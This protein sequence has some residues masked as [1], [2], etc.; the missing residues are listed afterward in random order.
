MALSTK[1][2]TGTLPG[3]LLVVLW[4][5]RGRLF[6][7][8]DVLPL[9]PL[10][11]VGAA[12]GLLT[13][14]W[15]LAFN[16]SLGPEFDFTFVERILIAGRSVWFH[17]GKL[18]WPADLAFIYPRWQIDTAAWWSFAF[19]VGVAL[20]AALAWSVRQRSRGPLAAWLFFGGTLFPVL[21]FFNLYTYRYSLVANHY[22][23]LA[24][25]GIITLVAAV[26]TLGLTRRGPWR[27]PLGYAVCG[28]VLAALAATTWAESHQF[29][30]AETL[31]RTTIR[32]NPAC[33]LAYNNLGNILVSR[34]RLTDAREVYEQA[35]RL[36]PDLA[37]SFNGLGMA[38]VGQGDLERG[39]ESYRRAVALDPAYGEAFNNL[40]VALGRARL[41]EEAIRN[42]RESIRID[43]GYATAHYN[44]ANALARLGRFEEAE[45]HYRAALRIAPEMAFAHYYLG[46]TLLSQGKGTE[47]AGHFDATFRSKPDYYQGHYEVGNLH[48]QQGRLEEAI[49]SYRRA[50]AIK[51][52]YAEAHC[53][54]GAALIRQDRVHEAI[55][56]YREALRI[57][58]D[59]AIA[60]N[61]LGRALDQTG[62]AEAALALYQRA[63]AIDPAYATAR[64]N[65][66]EA[67]RR[68]RAGTRQGDAR[69][70]GGE[71][72]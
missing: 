53:N 40:G 68:Q 66:E 71:R 61:N 54:L 27:R 20:L 31:Y 21:G 32:R 34:G 37:T 6:V 38:W 70:P 45:G 48:L 69:A 67:L 33:W 15:E 10:F 42:Y 25:L 12:G 18:F 49:Q 44:L 29:A 11:V 4:W 28:V 13:A 23:Y 59:Y 46:L 50:L 22:Q 35:L 43:P 30:N 14:H 52:D 26:V 36:K 55:G 51:P 65:L 9:I 7:R 60:A 57:R 24:S 39:I 41:A 1:T 63:L 19:P 16:R 72:R 58:P 47:A 2:V 62:Q 3:A 56:H 5:Q 17:L 64:A 8:R